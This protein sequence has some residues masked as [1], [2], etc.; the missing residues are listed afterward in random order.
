MESKSDLRTRSSA[1]SR[2]EHEPRRPVGQIPADP[3]T[4][5][6]ARPA[7]GVVRFLYS[8]N[9][10]YILSADLVF[11]GLEHHSARADRRPALVSSYWAWGRTR[12]FWLP[13]PAC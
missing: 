5:G 12:C 1:A 4:T 7:R 10:F 13:A 11:V 8:S 9:P 2:P 6:C 3:T